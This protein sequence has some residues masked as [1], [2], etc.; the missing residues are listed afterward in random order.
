MDN[1]NNSTDAHGMEEDLDN[2]FLTELDVPLVMG[3][4]G[5]ISLF[6]SVITLSEELSS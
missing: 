1:M 3:N 5:V 2:I 6:R 4:R